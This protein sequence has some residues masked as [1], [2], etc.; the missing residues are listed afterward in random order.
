MFVS[1]TIVRYQRLLIPVALLAMAIHRLPLLFNNKC[2]F[3]KLMGCGKNRTFDI[4]PDWQQW[5]LLAV[6][7]RKEDFDH[8]Y[9]S[10]II[11]WWWKTFCKEQWTILCEPLISHGKWSDKEP[12]TSKNKSIEQ[13]NKYINYTGPI[14]VLTRARIRLAKLKSFWGNVNSVA[15]IMAKAPGYVTSFGIGEAPFYLQ[16]TFSIWNSVEDVKNFAYKSKEHTDVIVK[17]RQENWYSEEL[18]ARFIPLASFGTV[19]GADPLKDLF[20]H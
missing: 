15:V 14:A 10:S 9:N 6:W 2:S 19:N 4:N 20:T 5:G 13:D 17:T 16:A 3:W 1:L 12:F 7:D 11:A 8:F 18:F